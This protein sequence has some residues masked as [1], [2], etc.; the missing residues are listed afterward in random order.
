MLA[1]MVGIASRG[2]RRVEPTAEP[3]P[4]VLTAENDKLKQTEADAVESAE[5]LGHA[6]EI[7]AYRGERRDVW[8]EPDGSFTE[9][10][11]QKAVRTV[12]DKR[13]VTPDA[14]LERNPDGGITPKAATF[15]L[16]L[17]GGGS[18]PFLTAERAGKTMSLTWPG[19]PL[20]A[21][22]IDGDTATYAEVEPGVDLVVHAGTENFSHVL[23][24]KNAAAAR[25]A[26]VANLALGLGTKGLTVKDVGG[27]RLEAVTDA[28]GGRVFEAAE[29][30]MWDSGDGR[31][32]PGASGRVAGTGPSALTED[33]VEPSRAAPLT[34]RKAP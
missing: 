3:R 34:A 15:G 11:H 7:G 20:P 9:Y 22:T 27:G 19:G 6:V 1:T 2:D 14:T 32:E 8:A 24:V 29:P 23:V 21:P 12:R 5:A 28:G 10:T 18:G 33:G 13:W 26:S 17:S 4:G 25:R 31:T 30:K 16:R